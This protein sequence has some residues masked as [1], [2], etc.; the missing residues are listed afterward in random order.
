MSSDSPLDPLRAAQEESY[1]HK[2]NQDIIVKMK[3]RLKHDRLADDLSAAGVSDD[4]LVAALLEVGIDRAKLPVLNLA[5]L[6]QVA[7]ADGEIQAEERTLLLDA[8]RAQ[9]IEDDSE[10]GQALTE[11]LTEPPPPEFYASA[12]IYI[13][14]MLAATEDE[15]PAAAKT[16]RTDL[17]S[18]A[19]QV[20]LSHG[21]LFGMFGTGVSGAE[22]TALD[23]ISA[24]LTQSHPSA[25]S[26]WMGKLD[27]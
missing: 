3:E 7:W 22:Q 1:F 17:T 15:D 4:T 26:D 24:Q 23:S 2:K 18:L 12:M 5:P 10:A 20:A 16:A 6:L 14:A 21:K 9:G 8:A 13:R 19:R 27:D 11:L 25:A